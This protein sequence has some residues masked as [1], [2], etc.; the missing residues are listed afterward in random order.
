MS[1]ATRGVLWR[2]V[3]GFGL[4]DRFHLVGGLYDRTSAVQRVRAAEEDDSLR[5]GP[6]GTMSTNSWIW[7]AILCGASKTLKHTLARST[8][9]S[10][11]Q[12]VPEDISYLCQHNNIWSIDIPSRA[13]YGKHG[14]DRAE[15]ESAFP[16]TFALFVKASMSESADQI[17]A[18]LVDWIDAHE[19]RKHCA[20]Q[21][22]EAGGFIIPSLCRYLAKAGV[23]VDC[24]MWTCRGTALHYAAG[25]WALDAIRCLLGLGANGDVHSEGS[26]DPIY[27]LMRGS[28][29]GKSFGLPPDGDGLA[30]QDT[31]IVDDLMEAVYHLRAPA[32]AESLPEAGPT[33]DEHDERGKSVLSLVFRTMSPDSHFHMLRS[34]D[35]RSLPVIIRS[36]GEERVSHYY[37]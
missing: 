1:S 35:F 26:L 22:W 37:V 21:V 28:R 11:L 7:T 6:L 9:T 19:T 29:P 3:D 13:A 18:T 14:L 4:I 23:P 20:Q 5:L 30:D 16:L 17:S 36:R 15:W 33:V 2:A 24:T 10:W 12:E 8:D 27:W 25:Y 31:S 32:A 34:D